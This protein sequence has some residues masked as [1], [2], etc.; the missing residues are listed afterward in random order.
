MSVRRI[1]VAHGGKRFAIDRSK[2]EIRQ[3]ASFH[4]R[5]TG[6]FGTLISAVATVDCRSP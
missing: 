2:V 1:P 5:S 4:Q 3:N 6:P